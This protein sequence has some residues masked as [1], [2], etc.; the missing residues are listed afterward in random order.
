MNSKSYIIPRKTV[1]RSGRLKK[2][3][4]RPEKKKPRPDPTVHN[5]TETKIKICKQ[6]SKSL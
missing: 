3:I 6:N 5:K 4:I 2:K 1:R